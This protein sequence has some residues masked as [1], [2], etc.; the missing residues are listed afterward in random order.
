[1]RSHY[2]V[3]HLTTGDL[4]RAEVKKGTPL[5]ER[6]RRKIEAGH[7]VDDGLVLDMVE[8]HLDSPEC[9]NGFLLDGFPR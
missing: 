6:I 4:L 3:C 5:G 1:M 7:L 8:G 2:S 9:A